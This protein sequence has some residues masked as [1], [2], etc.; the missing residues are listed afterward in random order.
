MVPDTDTFD[1]CM[2]MHSV[3]IS[4]DDA[5]IC[6]VHIHPHSCCLSLFL[7]NN[8]L[9]FSLYV[10]AY[11]CSMCLLKIKKCECWCS[12]EAH[13]FFFTD[14]PCPLSLSRV[15]TAHTPDAPRGSDRSRLVYWVHDADSWHLFKTTNNRAR[16]GPGSRIFFLS[17][18]RMLSL[19]SGMH[20]N[21]KVCL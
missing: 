19:G 2:M 5:P 20:A 3:P 21:I 18:S 6:A 15:L 8:F 14:S 7:N 9:P 12:Y 16:I 13:S 1:I 11:S 17:H 4:L 10:N